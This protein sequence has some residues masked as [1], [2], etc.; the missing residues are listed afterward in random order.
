M[1][2]FDNSATSNYKPL[3]VKFEFFR[4]LTKKYSANPGRSSHKL[5]SRVA[6]K[7]LL[8]RENFNNYFNNDCIDHIVFTSGCS[9]SLNTAIFGTIKQ[10]GHIIYTAF[11]HNS[12][13]RPVQKLFEDNKITYSVITPKENGKIDLDEL[14][15][16]V[17]E[18]TYLVI[19]NHT[20]NVIGTNANIKEIG[21]FCK[22]RKILF[23]VDGAQSAGH[24]KI[25]MQESNIDILCLAGHKGLLGPQGVGVLLY[26]SDVQITPLKYGGTGVMSELISPP[27]LPPESLEVGTIA[28]PNILALNEG[29]NYVKKHQEK[30]NKKC[31]EIS[32]YF[33][34]RI[35]S[36]EGIKMF[37]PQ[38]AIK[39]GIFT[40][41]L[42]G[43]DTNELANFLAENNICVRSGLHCA[44]LVHKHLKTDGG[45][46]RVSLSFKN[47]KREVDTFIEVIK[48]FKNQIA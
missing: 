36:I 24:E 6:N 15:K 30:I 47:K 44:P 43:V 45:A 8:C 12:V 25:D 29:L 40:F 18:K 5:A 13:I 31:E 2:Y 48:K 14:K 42:E 19:V 32:S 11:E 37:T 1:I 35:C 27:I 41:I 4:C 26:K 9:E 16:L 10:N 7:I 33:Y 34:G 21:E 20:S 39:N 3:K 28:S 23:M 17:N 38:C 46:I 22:E